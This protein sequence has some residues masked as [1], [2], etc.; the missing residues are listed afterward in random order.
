MTLD[1]V[2]HCNITQYIAKM[3]KGPA[4]ELIEIIDNA[5]SNR[6]RIAQLTD[7]MQDAQKQVIHYDIRIHNVL[8]SLIS[9]YF[10]FVI[11]SIIEKIQ[12][13]ARSESDA[14]TD[15]FN[16]LKTLVQHELDE[17]LKVLLEEISNF[18]FSEV[19]AIQAGFKDI[20]EK[21]KVADDLLAEGMVI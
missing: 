15:H 11:V 13:A 21:Q 2:G 14:L 9:V 6:I 19:S 16:K 5:K 1:V 7:V 17:R 3:N 18:E 8:L 20:E 4:D 12:W 10:L